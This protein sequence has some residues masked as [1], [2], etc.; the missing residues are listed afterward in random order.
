M[1]ARTSPTSVYDH[2]Y[3][4]FTFLAIVRLNTFYKQALYDYSIVVIDQLHTNINPFLLTFFEVL[5]DLGDGPVYSILLFAMVNWVATPRV[6]LYVVVIG[7][8]HLIM[9]I[10]KNL[11]HDPRPYFTDKA[12]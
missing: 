9:P 2:L 4:I 3:Y 1:K 10:S 7:L 5:S 11:H 12:T 8:S 6:F